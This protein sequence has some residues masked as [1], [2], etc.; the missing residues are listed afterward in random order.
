M[1]KIPSTTEKIMKTSDKL[2]LCHGIEFQF[3]AAEEV[4]RGRD[5]L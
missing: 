2:E 1:G 5:Q 4:G 3:R